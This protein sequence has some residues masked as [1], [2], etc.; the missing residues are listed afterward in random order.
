MKFAVQP[1]LHSLVLRYPLPPSS[2]LPPAWRR[3]PASFFESVVS[4]IFPGIT[5]GVR[6]LVGQTR[7][8]YALARSCS[9]TMGRRYFIKF[10]RIRHLGKNPPK[11]VK[12]SLCVTRKS[13]VLFFSNGCAL[14]RENMG[15]GVVNSTNTHLPDKLDRGTPDAVKGMCLD[16]ERRCRGSW[17]MSCGKSD[18]SLYETGEESMTE[19]SP[20]YGISREIGYPSLLPFPTSAKPSGVLFVRPYLLRLT[21]LHRYII[22]SLCCIA[23]ALGSSQS[24]CPLSRHGAII[25]PYTKREAWRDLPVSRR[26]SPVTSHRSLLTGANNGTE[27]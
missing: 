16:G 15:A 3:S 17:A 23:T 22:T 25:L 5:E 6:G 19:L 20:R 26:Q 1:R 13:Q 8:W 2:L 4:A 14:F 7:P 12:V 24:G 18:S 11:S 27:G 21:S 9:C 10:P